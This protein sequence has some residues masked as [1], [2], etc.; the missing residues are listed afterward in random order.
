MCF[1]SEAQKNHGSPLYSEKRLRSLRNPDSP[2]AF[3]FLFLI[4][5]SFTANS[6]FFCDTARTGLP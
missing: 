3:L 6:I 2:Q 4:L 5:L 1:V